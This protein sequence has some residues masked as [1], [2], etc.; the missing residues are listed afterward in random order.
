MMAEISRFFAGHEPDEPGHVLNLA[1]AVRRHQNVEA[2]EAMLVDAMARFPDNALI[3][4][5]LACYRGVMGRV[6]DAK[7]LLAEA[8]SRDASLRITALDDPD[9]AGVW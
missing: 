2:A 5:N 1:Y 4:Y 3:R 8:F 7:K 6:D 9:L